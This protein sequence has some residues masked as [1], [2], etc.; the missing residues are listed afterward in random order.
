MMEER[1]LMWNKGGVVTGS[2]ARAVRVGTGLY[3]QMRNGNRIQYEV[4]TLQIIEDALA[5]LFYQSNIPVEKRYTK[6]QVGTT[7]LIEISKL[8]Q[9]DFKTYNPFSD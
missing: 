2:G 9:D 4:L 3:E 8:L 5:N 1:D 7:T 6:I